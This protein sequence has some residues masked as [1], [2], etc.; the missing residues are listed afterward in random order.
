MDAPAAA[1][2]EFGSLGAVV[3]VPNLNVAVLA[4]AVRSSLSFALLFGA[5]STR[6]AATTNSLTHKCD[7]KT[8]SKNVIPSVLHIVV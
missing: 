1:L 4:F 5:N 6:D 3:V 2:F 8:M 7:P